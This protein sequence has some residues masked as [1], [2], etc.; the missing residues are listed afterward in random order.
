MSKAEIIQP[1]DWREILGGEVAEPS[2]SYVLPRKPYI[3]GGIFAKAVF[4]TLVGKDLVDTRV[5]S[6]V[7]GLNLENEEDEATVNETFDLIRLNMSN[8]RYGDEIQEA[9]SQGERASQFVENGGLGDFLAPYDR[10]KILP[11]SSNISLAMIEGYPDHIR[12]SC[13]LPELSGTFGFP[14]QLL[15]REFKGFETLRLLEENSII[16]GKNPEQVIR[17]MVDFKAGEIFIQAL[18][19]NNGRRPKIWEISRRKAVRKVE[20]KFRVGYPLNG[21]EIYPHLRKKEKEYVS[22]GRVGGLNTSLSRPIENGNTKGSLLLSFWFYD[23]T[24]RYNPQTK[25]M[26]TTGMDPSNRDVAYVAAYPTITPLTTHSELISLREEAVR[27]S[28]ELGFPPPDK[29][30]ENLIKD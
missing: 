25:Q 17:Q 12:L 24:V 2:Y 26:E 22:S 23:K 6:E 10:W 9:L 30:L 18:N 7:D 1:V 8:Q 16:F 15:S 14:N 11:I 21:A 5:I 4:K 13:L 29:Y 3:V 28:R 27:L 19:Q 20:E